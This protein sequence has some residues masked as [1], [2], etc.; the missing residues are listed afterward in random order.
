M[1][2]RRRKPPWIMRLPSGLR[3][4]PAWIFI[5]F[6]IGLAGVS[7]LTGFT[8]SSISQAIGPL[9]LR[10][11]GGVLA[12]S[13]FGIVF[14][15]FRADPALERFVLRVMSISMAVYMGWLFA[16]VAW[17]RLI[18]SLALVLILDGI[19]EIRIAVLKVLLKTDRE[20]SQ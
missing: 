12:A 8:E 13:G 18:M 17:D 6:L 20:G 10:I 1:P 4:Q 3:E 9:G 2:N 15:T 16:V 14:A 19:A 5:G 11:W 7:Y